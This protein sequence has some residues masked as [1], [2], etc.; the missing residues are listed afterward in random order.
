METKGYCLLC[1]KSATSTSTS[2]TSSLPQK[3][4]EETA[5][6]VLKVPLE[7]ND[8]DEDDNDT[9]LTLTGPGRVPNPS[10][11]SSSSA[12]TGSTSWKL[13]SLQRLT[14][15][16]NL[17]MKTVFKSILDLTPSSLPVLEKSELKGVLCSDC[18][19]LTKTISEVTL[20]LEILQ[21]TLY[22]C[23]TKLQ[24]KVEDIRQEGKGQG[25]KKNNLMEKFKMEMLSSPQT[26]MFYGIV[27][28]LRKETWK[29]CKSCYV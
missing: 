22:S 28:Q 29:K 23:L 1:L 18:A 13:F 10:S 15:Y 20:E 3:I 11:S 5:T 4:T 16:L 9:D 12:S 24:G 8:K 2:T 25:N 17:N 19:E 14:H 27:E 7:V 21:M 26:L 6:N